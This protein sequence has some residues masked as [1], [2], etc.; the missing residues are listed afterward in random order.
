VRLTIARVT[1]DDFLV[2]GL[3][4]IDHVFGEFD[5]QMHAGLI[6]IDKDINA[7]NKGKLM[8][9]M[10]EPDHPAVDDSLLIW[11]NGG[12][13]CSSFHAGLFLEMGPITTP[14][15][16]AGSFGQPEDA[17]RGYNTYAWTN[18]TTVMYVGT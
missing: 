5:G 8:F 9:W 1:K 11:F 18:A 4:E 13:G 12:P 6:S 7:D 16:P 17:P 14:L 3:E 10:F 2:T 15:Q